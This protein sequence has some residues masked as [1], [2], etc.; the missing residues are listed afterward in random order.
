[1]LLSR[2]FLLRILKVQS[3]FLGLTLI[4]PDAKLHEP[5]KYWSIAL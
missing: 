5:S 1:M 3:L 2:G 4:C